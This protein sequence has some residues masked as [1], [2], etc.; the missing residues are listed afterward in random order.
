MRRR[1][2][3]VAG[4]LPA[5]A[6]VVSA[7][8]VGWH[9]NDLGRLG[10]LGRQPRTARAFFERYQDRILFGKDRYAPEEFPAP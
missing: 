5:L 10:K 8:A 2:A 1:W 7:I 3:A 9:A 4:A 6:A